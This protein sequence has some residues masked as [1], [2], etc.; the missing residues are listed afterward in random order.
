MIRNRHRPARQDNKNHDNPLLLKRRGRG[1][2]IETRKANWVMPEA[3]S[4]AY[5]RNKIEAATFGPQ[6]LGYPPDSLQTRCTQWAH[7]IDWLK[8]IEHKNVI[9]LHAPA[10]DGTTVPVKI[11]AP[12]LRDFRSGNYKAWTW[13]TIYTFGTTLIMSDFLS[14]ECIF[15]LCK[16]RLQMIFLDDG[17][18]VLP[19]SDEQ[20]RD[21]LRRLKIFA[22]KNLPCKAVPIMLWQLKLLHPELQT[23]ATLWARCGAR[24]S[25]FSTMILSD[26][27][28][29]ENMWMRVRC[30][31]MKLKP[32]ENVDDIFCHVGSFAV[33]NSLYKVDKNWIENILMPALKKID[34]TLTTHSFR[35]GLAINIR[36]R[37]YELGKK[38]GGIILSRINHIFAWDQQSRSFMNYTNDWVRFIGRLSAFPEIV[39]IMEYILYGH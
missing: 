1:A 31:K 11:K 33:A 10:Y 29:Y 36:L 16:Q 38:P 6:E 27:L 39:E 8:Q 13:D 23:Q 20:H 15:S 3:L 18:P 35:R 2:T 25:S 14:W 7:L 9:T 17:R 21:C 24:F 19:F 22:G 37:L 12:S 28:I 4:A 26:A 5:Q 30:K 32:R 34:P